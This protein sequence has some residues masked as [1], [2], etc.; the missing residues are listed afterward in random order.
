V[1]E[2]RR[3][4]KRP[5]H[6]RPVAMGKEKDGKDYPRGIGVVVVESLGKAQ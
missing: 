4:R 3:R 5:G 2:H 6:P 1:A